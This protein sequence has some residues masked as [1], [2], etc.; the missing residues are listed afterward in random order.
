MDN[1]TTYLTEAFTKQHYIKIAAILKSYHDNTS[2]RIAKDLAYMFKQDNP[3]FDEA[4]F[5]QAAGAKDE[6]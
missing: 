1:F 4:R 5:M 6:M 2:G 3:A